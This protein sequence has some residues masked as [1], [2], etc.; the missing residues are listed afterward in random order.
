MLWECALRVNL[1]PRCD[2]TTSEFNY[3]TQSEINIIDKPQGQRQKQQG[4]ARNRGKKKRRKKYRKHEAKQQQE[5]HEGR[6]NA[7]DSAPEKSG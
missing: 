4:K 3:A 2:L 1:A 7:N 6:G 5:E